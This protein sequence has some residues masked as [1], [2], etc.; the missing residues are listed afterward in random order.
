LR[1]RI[2]ESGRGLLAPANPGAENALVS[3]VR[4]SAL[5]RSFC[6]GLRRNLCAAWLRIGR[7]GTHRKGQ[8][9]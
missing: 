9:Q 7:A 4:Q 8:W 5:A 6:V 3:F 2:A 1:S